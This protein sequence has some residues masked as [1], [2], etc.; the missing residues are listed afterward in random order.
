MGSPVV[1]PLLALLTVAALVA[2]GT[3][4]LL[5]GAISSSEQAGPAGALLVVN[6]TPY[7]RADLA[8]FRGRNDEFASTEAA[9]RA[10]DRFVEDLLLRGAASASRESGVGRSEEATRARLRAGAS[11]RIFEPALRQ[12]VA[13]EAGAVSSGP[14]AQPD[15]G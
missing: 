8:A 1:R 10:I 14:P 6:G 2:F 9:R 13:P 11:V 12:L 5:R 3:L 4:L 7:D 15:G